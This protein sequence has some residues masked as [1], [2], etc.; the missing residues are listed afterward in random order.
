MKKIDYFYLKGCPYCKKADEMLEQLLEENPQY[1][2]LEI[3]RIEESTNMEYCSMMDY[4][5]VPC[6]FVDG[7]NRH[8]GKVTNEALQKVLD[9]AMNG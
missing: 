5:Y 9:E 7:I 1:K 6:F 4:F 3:Y 8:E 2:K